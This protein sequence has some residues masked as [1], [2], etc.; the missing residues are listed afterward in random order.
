LQ[1]TVVFFS[2]IGNLETAQA[3]I[4]D[5]SGR[6]VPSVVC[7][8]VNDQ[9]RAR[10]LGADYCLVHPVT[11]DSF[12]AALTAASAPSPLKRQIRPQSPAQT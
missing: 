1:P 3:L 7:S 6:E 2:S 9:A 5:L 10:E 12:L 8:S 11:Y 4:A